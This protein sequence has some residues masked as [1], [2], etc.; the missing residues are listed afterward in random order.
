MSQVQISNL[1]HCIWRT[2]INHL[3]KSGLD[4]I[5]CKSSSICARNK[6]LWINK[7]NPPWDLRNVP[8]YFFLWK[9]NLKDLTSSKIEN[10]FS[11]LCF[12]HF[13]K[14][15]RNIIDNIFKCENKSFSSVDWVSVLYFL[16]IKLIGLRS[17]NISENKK[18][19]SF[20]LE[21]LWC[22]SKSNF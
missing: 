2:W 20:C 4:P 22:G 13:C 10:T 5:D 8:N 15:I 21:H 18:T 6:F 16:N 3:C 9:V 7:I 14:Q 17:P 12:L 19:L 1:D 11:Q